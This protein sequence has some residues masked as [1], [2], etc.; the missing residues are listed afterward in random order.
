[1]AAHSSIL[2]WEIPWWKSL[3]GYRTM[4]HKEPD[5]IEHVYIHI[6]I[7]GIVNGWALIP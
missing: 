1:M 4:G 7:Y 5:T 6:Y 3:V 2:A